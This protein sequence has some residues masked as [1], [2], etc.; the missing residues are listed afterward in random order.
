MRVTLLM[1]D[2]DLDGRSV[3][4]SCWLIPVGRAVVQGDRLLEL[5][6]GEVLVD[7]PSP[8]T[9]RLVETHVAEGDVVIPNQPLATIEAEDASAEAEPEGRAGRS[10]PEA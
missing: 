5:S 2:L 6:A 3:T 7:L 10:S 8:A 1:P 9:G 4:A